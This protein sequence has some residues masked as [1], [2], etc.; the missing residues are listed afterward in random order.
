MTEHRAFFGDGE[1]TFA[2]TNNEILELERKTGSGIGL[3]YQQ[4][5]SAQFRLPDTLEVIRLGLIGGGTSPLEAHEL[6]QAYSKSTPV[7]QVFNLAF[8][9]LETRWSGQAASAPDDGDAV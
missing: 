2:L 6:V 5:V 4:F 1:K 3:I 8:D 9:I 7:V